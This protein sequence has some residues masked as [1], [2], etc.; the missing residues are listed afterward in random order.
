MLTPIEVKVKVKVEAG[1]GAG[2]EV[3]PA[4]CSRS[5]TEFS[6]VSIVENVFGYFVIG[7]IGACY[8]PLRLRSRTENSEQ[9]TVNGFW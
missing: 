2:A 4:A 5:R 7:Y 8:P 1:A 6:G 9:R 3:T